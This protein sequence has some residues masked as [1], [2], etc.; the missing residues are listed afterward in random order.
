MDSV[1]LEKAK[2][3]AQDPSIELELR[4]EIQALIDQNNASEL[5]ERFHTDLEFGTGG[6]RSFYQAGSNRVN[7]VTIRRAAHA[8]ALAVKEAYP[9]EELRIAISFDCRHGSTELA[10]Q[11]SLV[12]AAHGIKALIYSRLNPV[13][14]LSWSIRYHKAH[15]GVMVTASHNPMAYNGFKVYWNDGAQ[16]TPPHD[17][18]IINYYNKVQSLDEIPR[19]SMEEARA[20]E[21]ISTVGLDVEE[22]Y[23]KMLLEAAINPELCREKGKNLK[24]VFTPIHGTALNPAKAA[25]KNLGFTQV[26]IP[27]N[28]AQPDGDFS[29][30]KSPNPENPEALSIAVELM[31]KNH[32]DIVM[33]SDPDGDRLGLALMHNNEVV[34]PNGNQIGTLMLFY[35]LENKK[36]LGMLKT[37]SYMVKSIVTT[38]LLAKIADA[39]GV[40]CFN[41]LTGFKWICAKMNET[42]TQTPNKTF[43]FATEESFGYLHHQNVRD[44]DGI[45][46]IT[47]AA[48]MTLWYRERGMN[49]IQALDHI[50]E[51]FGYSHETL[52]SLDYLGLEGAAKI[53]RIMNHFRNLSSLEFA[54]QKIKESQD[55]QSSVQFDHVN[56]TQQTLKH[57]K[58]N[59][60]GFKFENG[61]ILFLRPSGTEPK[62]KF[63]IM[64]HENQGSL[65]EKKAAS[66]MRTQIFLETI[67]QI[68]EKA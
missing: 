26:L 49:L 18:V 14:L 20:Q 50:Y 66:Q 28:Q 59:V 38:P 44:K 56:N 33:G 60:L 22:A 31:K 45:G 53:N 39:Y 48:E 12:F 5:T 35:L 41:T 30:V 9:N 10:N 6:M 65:P 3:W 58:S 24:I 51:R 62:I 54:S 68:A 8:L 7:A 63:Y 19:I 16:V 29:T 52:L 37:S 42:E 21:K 15:A 34:Y 27:E 36:T 4:Q 55:Y 23:Q 61:D 32:S 40:E 43:V 11:A 2:Q 46:S 25:L 64:I 17:R 57:P 13:P 67:Q 1:I 47:L